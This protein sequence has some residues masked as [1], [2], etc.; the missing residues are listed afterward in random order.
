MDQFAMMPK[1][2]HAV[3]QAVFVLTV[4]AGL[5]V[6]RENLRSLLKESAPMART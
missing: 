3:M 6:R 1:E 4:F 5:L 2:P